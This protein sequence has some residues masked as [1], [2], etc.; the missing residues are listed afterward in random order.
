VIRPSDYGE[1]APESSSPADQSHAGSR[2]GLDTGWG[3]RLLKF[4]CFREKT[5]KFIILFELAHRR[6]G[7][8][9]STRGPDASSTKGRPRH[10]GG[11]F[12]LFS[13]LTLEIPFFS[14]YD[15]LIL[16]FISVRFE[17]APRTRGKCGSTTCPG[18]ARLRGELEPGRGFRLLVFANSQTFMFS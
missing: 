9:G 1:F 13:F 6:R 11:F 10:G 17:L 3:F 5:L 2:G 15:P 18:R 14:R 8:G 12:F 7:T 4:P 16:Q